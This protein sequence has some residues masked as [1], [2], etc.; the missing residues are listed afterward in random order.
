MIGM[1]LHCCEPNLAEISIFTVNF[2][3]N[4]LELLT[5]GCGI[6]NRPAN[7]QI[8]SSI[9]DCSSGRSYPF[10]IAGAV[11]SW[12]DTRGDQNKVGRKPGAQHRYFTCRT[13]HS[14]NVTVC[15]K[16]RKSQYESVR[17]VAET[18][19]VQVIGGKA[20]EDSYCREQ[21]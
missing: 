5:G 13:Y 20:G 3:E 18:N 9:S 1:Q 2:S 15:C 6:G 19:I 11:T 17:S 16:A 14:I 21:G 7:Y 8:V 10:L 4:V 12:S